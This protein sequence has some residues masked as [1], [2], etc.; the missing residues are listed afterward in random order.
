MTKLLVSVR[1]A[2]EARVALGAGV[3]L[4]DVKEPD[5]GSLGAADLATIHQVLLA[6]NGAAPVSAALGELSDWEPTAEVPFGL[7][8]AKI[9]LA[10]CSVMPQWQRLWRSAIASF[11]PGT[12]AVA[13]VYADW[14]LAQSPDPQV[15]LDTAVD[16]GCS[17]VLIDTWDKSAGNLL[18]HWPL[19]DL[20]EFVSCARQRGLLTVLAGSLSLKTLPRVL[21]LDPDYVA[22]RGAACAAT[23]TGRLDAARTRHLV[24]FVSP[25]SRREPRRLRARPG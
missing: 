14:R 8:F 15:T 2:E 1:D 17:A 10:G 23:R 25:L 12:A 13:V 7:R 19:G 20:G 24:E 3:D 5:R 22:V 16:L 21:S 18:D 11:G 9:G 6:V 4:I